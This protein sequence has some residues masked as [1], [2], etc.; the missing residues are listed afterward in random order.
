MEPVDPLATVK[1]Q[2][3]WVG[4]FTRSRAPGAYPNGSRVEKVATEEGDTHPIGALATVLG[5]VCD[6]AQPHLGIG[7]FVEWDAHPRRAVLVV[8]NKIRPAT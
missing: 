5:S 8:A 4:V 6:L 3:G 2:D 1:P 7:Y